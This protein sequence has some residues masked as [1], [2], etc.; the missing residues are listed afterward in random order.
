MKKKNKL[1]IGQ[2]WSFC[3]NY[4][5]DP[6]PVCIV[7]FGRNSIGERTVVFEVVGQPG[8]SRSARAVVFERG[9]RGA[10][11]LKHA[12]GTPA[13]TTEHQRTSGLTLISQRVNG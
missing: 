4:A 6:A 1:V 10:F 11:L 2:T 5:S 13:T 9:K 8:R 3:L 7:G 12:D